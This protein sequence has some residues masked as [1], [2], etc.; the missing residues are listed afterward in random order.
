VSK[1]GNVKTVVDNITFASK[2]EAKRYGELKLMLKAG[3][4][5]ELE[6]QPQ[7]RLYVN[8]VLIC[9]YIADFVYIDNAASSKAQD[10]VRVVEDVKGMKTAA[11]RL[12]KKLMKAIY[13]IEVQEI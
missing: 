6:L 1:Y 4:I 8:G 12:K 11:Y 10:F 2:K 3:E 5:G 7:Y 13:G 9:R